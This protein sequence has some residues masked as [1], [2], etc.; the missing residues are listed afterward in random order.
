MTRFFISEPETENKIFTQNIMISNL[1]IQ[2]TNNSKCIC[3]P[4]SL[5][6]IHVRLSA[7]HGPHYNF[8]F[9]VWFEVQCQMNDQ[10][11]ILWMNHRFVQI[12]RVVS[13][14][15]FF[16]NT[17]INYSSLSA[18]CKTNSEWHWPSDQENTVNQL[19]MKHKYT[20]NMEIVF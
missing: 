19:E 12:Q 11:G 15:S 2:V 8:W 20:L 5:A 13:H 10:I 7:V 18:L 4:S 9:E 6:Y 16:N 14:K 3:F 1:N 17:E